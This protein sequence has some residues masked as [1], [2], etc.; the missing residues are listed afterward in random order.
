MRCNM[1]VLPLVAIVC[2]AASVDAASSE[3]IAPADVYELPILSELTVA[4][5]GER[6]IYGVMRADRENDE[7]ATQLWELDL[8]RGTSQRWRLAP[9]GAYAAKFSPD[10]REVAWL[11]DHDDATVLAVAE[12]PK[13]KRQVLLSSE[14]GIDE[15]AWAPNGRGFAVVKADPTPE[16]DENRPWVITRS[17]AQSDGGVYSDAPRS[18]VHWLDRPGRGRHEKARLR[19]LTSGDFDDEQVAVS[20]DGK[21]VAF[22]SNRQPDPDATDDTDLFLLAATGGEPRRL[23]SGA[24]PDSHPVWSPRGDRLAYLSVRRANDYYQPIRL[25]TIAVGDP[26]ATA[27]DLTGGLDAWVAVDSLSA[28]TGPA[29]PIWSTGADEIVVPIERR[30]STWVAQVPASGGSPREVSAKANVVHGFVRPI[31]GSSDLLGTI[32]DP[33]HPPELFRWSPRDP[34]TPPRQLTHLY[35]AWLA[36]HPLVTPRKFSTRNPEGDEVEAWLY[37]PKGL[38]QAVAKGDAGKFPLVVYIHGGPQGFDGEFFDF[39]LENQLF[40]ERGWGVLRVNYRGSTAYGEKFSRSLWGDWHRREYDDLM[41]A[42]DAAIAGN[43]WIDEKRLGIG[44]WSYGGIMTLWTV[45]HTDRFAVGVPE[46]FGFDYLSS[47]GE[48][49]WWV[50]YQSE[51]G[52]PLENEELYRRLSPGTYLKNVKTPLYLIA[53]EQDKNCPLPQVLQAYQRLKLMGQKTELVIYPGEAHSMASPRNLVDRLE[54]LVT[55]FGRH[56]DR[57]LD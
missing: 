53:N 47:Y 18:H 14:E 46:R 50:W 36:K 26:S 11:E 44:G 8:A 28:G 24:G 41:A 48:D 23:P 32:T 16:G 17:L 56:L 35:D 12:Y 29:A 57:Q 33:T 49:Q 22:V 6:A 42:L 5:S 30:G 20:P 15:F 2:A 21:W 3:P 51:L 39:D 13:G 54:R 55:W 9:D 19:Q 38:A 10:G 52:S 43:S 4:P 27:V 1:R 45:G 25:A 37:P 31:P 7:F 34:A 40:P